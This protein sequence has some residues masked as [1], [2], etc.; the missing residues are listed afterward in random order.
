MDLNSCFHVLFLYLFQI[1][2][3]RIQETLNVSVYG[4][5]HVISSSSYSFVHFHLLNRIV[6]H[7]SHLDNL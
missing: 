2:D 5:S 7:V 6:E 1:P 3:S 4:K